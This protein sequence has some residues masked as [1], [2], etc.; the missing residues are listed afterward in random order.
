M[1]CDTTHKSALLGIFLLF[2]SF[3]KLQTISYQSKMIQFGIKWDSY[4]HISAM[5]KM[6]IKQGYFNF[7]VF[8]LFPTSKN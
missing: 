3:L 7:F 1:C 6:N 2:F 4:Q 8:N 5:A